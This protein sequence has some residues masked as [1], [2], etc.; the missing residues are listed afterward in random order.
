MS[1]FSASETI[2]CPKEL[3]FKQLTDLKNF[4]NWK[5]GILDIKINPNLEIS[6]GTKYIEIRRF[7]NGEGD[8]HMEVLD[9]NPPNLFV[10]GF[11]MGKTYCK[12]EY[13][14]QSKYDQTIVSLNCKIT[15]YGFK[16]LWQPLI[17]WAIKLQDKNQLKALKA[18]LENS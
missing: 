5:P 11:F 3:V 13:V 18:S 1:G 14:L 16:K 2:N 12:Y 17:A 6:K 15:V 4:K 9:I 10:T 8:V 7:K